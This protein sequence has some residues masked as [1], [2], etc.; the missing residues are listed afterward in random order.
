VSYQS[1]GT[2]VKRPIAL[3]K[4]SPEYVGQVVMYS[5]TESHCSADR[6]RDQDDPE[7]KIIKWVGIHEAAQ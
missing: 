7:T 2:V 6:F 3:L 5:G 1:W 4:M